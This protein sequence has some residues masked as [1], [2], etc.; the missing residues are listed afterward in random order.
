MFLSNLKEAQALLSKYLPKT[1]SYYSS[2]RNYSYD[3]E[4]K[5]HSTSLLSPYIR[6]R[7]ISEEDIIKK[8]L[9]IHPFFKVEKFIQKKLEQID[10][11]VTNWQ[12]ESKLI[13]QEEIE[14]KFEPLTQKTL[15]GL[16]GIIEEKTALIKTEATKEIQEEMKSFTQE[17]LAEASKQAA[18]VKIFAIAALGMS[19]IAII[20]SFL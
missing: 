2:K 4:N 3:F 18:Q 19:I 10:N 9:A 11:K 13:V 6:Y 16:E 12:K 20:I 7:L 17:R 8:V 5:V 15:E 1:G 14:K